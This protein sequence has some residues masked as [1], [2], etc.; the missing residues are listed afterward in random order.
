MIQLSFSS[1][2]HPGPKCLGRDS[3][4]SGTAP[5]PLNLKPRVREVWQSLTWTTGGQLVSMEPQKLWISC[6]QKSENMLRENK[7]QQP[8]NQPNQDGPWGTKTTQENGSRCHWLLPTGS[9]EAG[10]WYSH[11]SLADP[12]QIFHCSSTMLGVESPWHCPT[13]LSGGNSWRNQHQAQETSTSTRAPLKTP[14]YMGSPASCL[15]GP[16]GPQP[17]PRHP[18]SEQTSPFPASICTGQNTSSFCSILA[19]LPVGSP[20]STCQ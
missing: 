14:P 18:Q 4:P 8:E 19:I 20:G 7:K 2:A 10:D 5:N 6:A 16:Q 12:G 3:E 9:L 15:P 1:E 13:A 11:N 17:T